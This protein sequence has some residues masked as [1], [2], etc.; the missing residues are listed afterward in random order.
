MSRT[1]TSHY[2]LSLEAIPSSW[3]STTVGDAMRDIQPGFA[4]GIHNQEGLGI[5]HLR[6]MNVDREGKLDLSVVKYVSPDNALR[7]RAGDVLFNNTNS[8]ELIGKTAYIGI[9][10]DLAFSNHMTRLRPGK[11]IDHR[12]V[13]YQLHFLWMTGY[14]MH[15]CTHHVNQASISSQTLGETVP[16][17]V[18]PGLTQVR[19]VEEIEKQFTRLDAAVAA[20]KRVKANLKRYRAAVLK[21]ACEGCLVPTEA[22][23]ARREGRPYEPASVL[24]E[25]ILAER[26]SLWEASELSKFEISGKAPKDVRWKE[27]HKLPCA[28]ASGHGLV[29]PEG[30]A[31]GSL[32]QLT[33]AVRVI[34]YGILMPKEDIPDGVPY[35]RVLDLKG[36]RIDIE[37]LKRT[38]SAIAR[39]YARASLKGGDVLLAIRGS[40]GR[41][42]EVPFELEG[43]N[44]T[45]D[46]ARLEVSQFVDHRYIATCLRSPVAQN[47]F[48]RV[49][50]GVA[51]KGVNIADV[52][53]CPIPVPPYPEQSRIAVE[54]ERRLSIIDE[55]GTQTDADLRR[56]A[57]LRQSI[58]KRAFE[59]QLVPQNLNDEPASVL[60]ERVRTERE[61]KSGSVKSKKQAREAGVR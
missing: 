2:P 1:I 37:N 58:L 22:E 28:P 44:I 11:G 35:V 8:A 60:L 46:T 10:A 20:L 50:R 55:L 5:P 36:D 32:E 61:A 54:V 19:I 33:S 9:D 21:A 14:F 6:P 47:Y 57:R 34:C 56:A 40:Y 29:V 42:A 43:G 12:F 7:I 38:S 51:V 24:L 59:G 48:K 31:V 15:R 23:L 25:R 41:V 39:A 52:R 49:A 45:Q 26:R 17:V 27:K 3:K 18:P 53:L 30:W 13:A 4:S 16:L